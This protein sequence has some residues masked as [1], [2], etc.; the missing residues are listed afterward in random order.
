MWVI[1]IL[2]KT[3][4]SKYLLLKSTYFYIISN[5]F[6]IFIYLNNFLIEEIR[7]K[8]NSFMILITII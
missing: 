2:N 1:R 7:I 5:I 6:Q 3:K 8:E 4:I